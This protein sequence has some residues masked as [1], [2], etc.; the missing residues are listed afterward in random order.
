MRENQKKERLPNVEG[1]RVGL[2]TDGSFV[3]LL[4]GK[5]EL[6]EILGQPDGERVGSGFVGPI[7]GFVEGKK[8]GSTVGAFVG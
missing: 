5:A 1:P 2:E 7:V 3:G 6:G 8:E 4:V